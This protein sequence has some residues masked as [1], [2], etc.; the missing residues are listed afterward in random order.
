FGGIPA[1]ALGHALAHLLRRLVGE[2]DGGDAL[3]GHAPGADQVGDLLHD[4]AGLAAARAGEHEQGAVVVED[5]FALLGVETVHGGTRE[6]S[7]G[8]TAGTA[9]PRASVVASHPVYPPG[10]RR[11]AILRPDTKWTRGR[12]CS[13]NWRSPQ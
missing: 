13:G 9:S 11:T 7:G 8:R 5:G 6:R 2:G 1:D 10:P 12:E 3:G 4:H